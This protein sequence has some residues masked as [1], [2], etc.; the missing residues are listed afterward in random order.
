MK[1]LSIQELTVFV[2]IWNSP[3]FSKSLDFSKSPNFSKIP[4]LVE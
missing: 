1:K 4:V 2:N 3:D